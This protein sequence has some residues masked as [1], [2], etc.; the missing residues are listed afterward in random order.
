MLFPARSQLT[1]GAVLV[2]HAGE[3][4]ERA[5]VEQAHKRRTYVPC[6]RGG[7][8][9]LAA[10]VVFVPERVRWA[11]RTVCRSGKSAHRGGGE[12]EE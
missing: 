7:P 6:R 12:E 2:F 10:A 3:D 4:S 9:R 5:P 1:R 8:R 11:P